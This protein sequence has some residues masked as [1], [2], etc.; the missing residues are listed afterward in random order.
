MVIASWGN[1]TFNLRA[2]VLNGA[3]PIE[4]NQ[5][6]TVASGDLTLV[7]GTTYRYSGTKTFTQ[8]ITRLS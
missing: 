6:F 5:S 8:V 7:S 3:T 4:L 2:N 1:K